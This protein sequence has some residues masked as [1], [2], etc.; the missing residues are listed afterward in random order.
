MKFPRPKR[1]R[2][3]E[4]RFWIQKGWIEN[5]FEGARVDPMALAEWLGN[6]MAAVRYGE[7]DENWEFSIQ[8]CEN[9]IFWNPY[10]KAKIFFRNSLWCRKNAF[11]KLEKLFGFSMPLFLKSEICIFEMFESALRRKRVIP[12]LRRFISAVVDTCFFSQVVEAF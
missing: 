2:N 4:A 10:V 5:D 8:S 7:Y 9:E 3:V 11:K 12:A 1:C 6:R